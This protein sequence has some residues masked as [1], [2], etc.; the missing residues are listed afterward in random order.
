MGRL[1]YCHS[2]AV[3]YPVVRTGHDVHS[4][5]LRRPAPVTSSQLPVRQWGQV[6]VTDVGQVLLRRDIDMVGRAMVGGFYSMRFM[7]RTET[8]VEDPF[9]MSRYCSHPS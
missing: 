3:R 7:D 1:P 5:D 2:A 6:D 8:L 4:G 9:Q